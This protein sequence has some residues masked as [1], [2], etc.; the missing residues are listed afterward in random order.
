MQRRI[1]FLAAA[2]AFLLFPLLAANGCSGNDKSPTGSGLGGGGASSTSA[3][4]ANTGGSGGGITIKDGGHDAPP[5]VMKNPCGSKCG[6]TELCDPDHVGLDDN[7]NGTV[8]EGCSC[9]PGAVHP[10]F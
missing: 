3:S 5:D 10:C 4:T 8:D 2:A 1:R 6:P 7:C 9:Q